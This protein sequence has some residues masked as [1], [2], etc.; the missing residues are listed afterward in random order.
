MSG[1][2]PTP[3]PAPAPTPVAPYAASGGYET[4]ILPTKIEMLLVDK[5]V[6]ASNPIGDWNIQATFAMV[7]RD[8]TTKQ[9]LHTTNTQNG[10]NLL[11]V[12]SQ[13]NPGFATLAQQVFAA[14]S[15][16]EPDATSFNG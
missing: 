4:V 9:V 6:T 3:T 7:V 12:I 2:T 5:S 1:T 8:A 15:S 16:F 14:I 13:A 11:S 10:G